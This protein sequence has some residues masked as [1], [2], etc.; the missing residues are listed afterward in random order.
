MQSPS[1][2]YVSNDAGI[3][4][5][6]ATDFAPAMDLRADVEMHVP[7][8][9]DLA[10]MS[11][12]PQVYKSSNLEERPLIDPLYASAF[13]SS[14]W[15]SHPF[16]PSSRD[17]EDYLRGNEGTSLIHVINYIGSLYARAGNYQLQAM[18]FPERLHRYPQNGFAVQSLILLAISS[19]MSNNLAQAQEFLHTAIDIALAIGLHRHGFDTTH[20]QG[21]RAMTESWRRTW[22]ELYILDIMFAGLNQ[23]S[24]MW[25][26]DVE[27]DVLL[28][29]EEAIYHN[30]DVCSSDV[31]PVSAC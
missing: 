16:L 2:E 17:I 31:R 7:R 29:C 22:W 21:S 1:P 3:R 23:T 14:F 27:S 19:H 30:N 6:T 18:T 26:K 5:K 13:Y 28:P 15:P 4:P 9:E 8:F 11:F 24:N 20:G 10:V 25:L 12:Q